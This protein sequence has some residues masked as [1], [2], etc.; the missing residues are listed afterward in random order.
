MTA[1]APGLSVS[2]LGQSAD[3]TL[4]LRLRRPRRPLT[5]WLCHDLRR[6]QTAGVRWLVPADSSM[7]LRC[8]WERRPL[9]NCI[10]ARLLMRAIPGDHGAVVGMKLQPLPSRD[11]LHHVHS[12]PVLCYGRGC[13]SLVKLRNEI[14]FLMFTRV[15][16]RRGVPFSAARG[17]VGAHLAASG[18]M[19]AH[20]HADTT[21]AIRAP[22]T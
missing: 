11:G 15:K 5:L 21:P 12:M 16:Y 13:M 8:G 4:E 3:A 20:T 18:C 14:L 19:P 2:T 22:T 9:M 10:C 7:C 6:R 17:R 1:R